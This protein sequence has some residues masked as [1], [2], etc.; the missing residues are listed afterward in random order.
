MKKIY[1]LY[2]DESEH[3]LKITSEKHWESERSFLENSSDVTPR[4]NSFIFLSFDRAALVQKGNEIKNEWLIKLF[5]E[6]NK[7][8]NIE[9][10]R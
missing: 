2:A 4:F 1:A 7:V 6:M 3:I 5:N 10:R 8:A 9:L